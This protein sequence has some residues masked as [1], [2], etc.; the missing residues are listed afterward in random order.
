[1]D[2]PLLDRER[3]LRD[4]V[5]QRAVVRDEQHRSGEGF[6]RRFERLA[7]FE[8]E[9]VRRLVEHE[10]VRARRDDVG[11]REAPALAA[12]QHRDGLLVLVPAGEE[13]AAEQ[14][15]RLRALEARRPLRR[16]EHGVPLVELDL[17]LREVADLDGVPDANA[18]LFGL[19]LADE[20]AQERRLPC[21]VRA[22]ERDVLAALERERRV[23]Q[24]LAL[25]DPQRDV[26]R[27]DDGP[28]AA[29]R[30]DEAEAEP[31]RAAR[32]ERDLLL[33][34]DFSCE[35]RPICV[36]LACACFAFD[37]L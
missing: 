9:V 24:Q 26:V 22:D 30:V 34:L 15:L 28:P 1:M 32:Q 37:F 29:R 23:V 27:L 4:G 12:G 10:E 20:R 19:A 5:D 16:L 14:R 6:E 21:A 11:E 2:R 3:P 18:A 36:S 33:S 35:R 8:V 17:L 25:A 7:R 31:P 13:E